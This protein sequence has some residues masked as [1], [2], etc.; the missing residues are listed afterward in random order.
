MDSATGG[1]TYA[2]YDADDKDCRPKGNTPLTTA[3]TPSTNSNDGVCRELDVETHG[4][5]Y[6]GRTDP[7]ACAPENVRCS[8][9]DR[10]WHLLDTETNGKKYDSWIAGRDLCGNNG[11]FD[12]NKMLSLSKASDEDKR[13]VR[14]LKDKQKTVPGLIYYVEDALSKKSSKSAEA[15]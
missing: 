15:N 6:A 7:F 10:T 3:W 1:Y 8:Y 11:R 14:N 9:R 2:E 12:P 13:I 5:K 4:N